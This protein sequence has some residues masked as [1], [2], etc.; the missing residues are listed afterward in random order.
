MEA[1]FVNVFVEKQREMIND[2]VSRN[3]MLDARLS[4]AEQKSVKMQEY[5]QAI[6]EL[7]STQTVLQEQNQ[8]L[9]QETTV[10]Q[11]RDNE[12]AH[13][14]ATMAERDVDIE[15]L[16]SSV[17]QLTLDSEIQAAKAN[18]IKSKAKQLIEE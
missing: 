7:Q 12:I 10:I 18:R 1:E 6:L 17:K 8:K 9:L 3:V 14:R 16:R 2:L 15:Q 11:Q 4:F 13:L 5:E